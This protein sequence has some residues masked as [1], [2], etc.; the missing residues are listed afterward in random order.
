MKTIRLNFAKLLIGL[1]AFMGS[2]GMAAVTDSEISADEVRERAVSLDGSP[3]LPEQ[4]ISLLKPFR[5]IT[6]GEVHGSNEIPDFFARLA[7]RLS[8]DGSPLIVALEVYRPLNQNGIDQFVKSGDESILKSLPHFSAPSQDGRGSTAMAKLL[9]S[10]RALPSVQIVAFDMGATT[11]GPER[12]QERDSRMALTLTEIMR[13]YPNTRVVILAGNV[14]AAVSVGNSFDPKYRPMGFE[15][16]HQEG[17]IVKPNQVYS[18]LV[19]QQGGQTWVR[20]GDKPA[21]ANT[22]DTEHSVFTDAVKWNSYFLPFKTL[23][24]NGYNSVLFIRSLSASAPYVHST[25]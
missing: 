14:H 3:E 23:S 19:K 13:Q 11:G 12:G 20:V 5:V 6:V 17:S 10:L 2:S 7:G 21:M 18:I 4:M 25:H 22:L 16:S 8:R 9:K 1:L 24:K 15:L